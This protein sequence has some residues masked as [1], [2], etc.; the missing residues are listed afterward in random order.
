MGQVLGGRYE[1]LDI[2]GKGGMGTVWRIRDM[3][4]ET[5]LAGKVFRQSDAGSFLRY[6]R[7]TTTRISHEHVVMPLGWAGE[8]DHV[9]FA[10]P[11]VDGGSL[12]ELRSTYGALPPLYVAE[13]MRQ[14]M[15][16]LV[17]VHDAG[18]IHRDLKP[19][20]V[21]LYATGA[22]RP[23]AMLTDFGIAAEL[24][25]P[26]L[27]KVSV[28]LGTPGY[29]APEVL[30]GRDPHSQQDI[31]AAGAV[32]YSM[33]TGQVPNQTGHF[34]DLHAPPRSDIP[35]SMWELLRKM[36]AWEVTDRL[37]TAQEVLDHLNVPELA[38]V[39]GA[40]GPI[41]VLSRLPAIP[42]SSLP[43]GAVG[44]ASSWSVE[45]SSATA[46]DNARP[47]VSEDF[48]KG[49]PFP[50]VPRLSTE[51]MFNPQRPAPVDPTQVQQPHEHLTDPP[52][53]SKRLDLTAPHARQ[54]A[55]PPSVS[56]RVDLTAPHARQ[57]TDPPS[58]SKRIDDLTAPH[59][60]HNSEHIAQDASAPG[61]APQGFAATPDATPKTPKKGVPTWA[62]VVVAVAV[63][64][65]LIGGGYGVMTMMNN[66]DVAVTPGGVSKNP[67]PKTSSVPTQPRD[68]YL[69][70]GTPCSSYVEGSTSKAEDGSTLT[71][72][73]VPGQTGRYTWSK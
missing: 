39:D 34:D 48:T 1:L 12:A 19:A 68:T 56:K 7:E 61:A 53:I 67:S 36:V 70:E 25:G 54:A 63:L 35:A 9:V 6:M 45:V 58:V 16:G 73:A 8:D 33:L 47:S 40:A 64:L 72:K 5:I 71:C 59:A 2:I 65:G 55:D 52:S 41:K 13:I 15:S 69:K 32:M 46:V 49:D 3:K 60:T 18:V 17:A 29:L 24:E 31:F 66:N 37:Q 62:W 28:V 51:A 38:W 11:L 50:D 26:R 10:M 30:R 22:G 21:L 42:G 20:N 44:T 57:A 4:H 27:T 43:E 14:I 23:F